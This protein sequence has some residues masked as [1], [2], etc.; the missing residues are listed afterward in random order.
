MIERTENLL[1][2]IVVGLCL[3]MALKQAFRTHSRGWLLLAMMYA[4]FFLG[5]IYWTLYLFFY[6]KTPAVFYVSELSWCATYLLMILL[7]ECF[8]TD[9]ERSFRHPVIWL[10]PVF[11]IAMTVFYMTRGDYLLNLTEGFLMT[12]LMI[13]AVQGLLALRGKTDA[14]KN[15][16]S[17][18]LVFCLIEYALWTASCF[19]Q[20]DSFRN[21]YFW[22]AIILIAV[23]PFFY[24]S[25]RKAE[26]G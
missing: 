12:W 11:V 24:L 10:V 18:S 2:I 13:R 3:A 16:Y 19:W 20:G 1:E 9:A 5:D 21:S 4:C 15:L 22:F 7:L 26:G 14:R 17:T 23:Q 6:G 25:V 8:Q